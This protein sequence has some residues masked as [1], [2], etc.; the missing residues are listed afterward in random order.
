MR[1]IF[2]IAK[3][4]IFCGFSIQV[5]AMDTKEYDKENTFRINVKFPERVKRRWASNIQERPVGKISPLNEKIWRTGNEDRRF[6]S[7]TGQE[8]QNLLDIAINKDDSA[9][10]YALLANG[11]NPNGFINSPAPLH[12][13]YANSNFNIIKSLLAFKADPDVLSERGYT[14]LHYACSNQDDFLIRLLLKYNADP[15]IKDRH[16]REP[17]VYLHKNKKYLIEMLE[18]RMMKIAK[19]QINLT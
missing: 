10:V 16:Q 19:Q 2:G 4:F 17:I 15:Y 7:C 1:D 9:S 13:A 3:L 8:I 14:L 12:I 11:A 6:F 18:K 5:L